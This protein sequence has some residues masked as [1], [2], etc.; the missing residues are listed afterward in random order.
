MIVHSLDRRGNPVIA[1]NETIKDLECMPLGRQD[2][3]NCSSRQFTIFML[4]ANNRLFCYIIFC[5]AW[6]DQDYQLLRIEHF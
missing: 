5:F 6:R 2:S 3:V 1:R 4:L